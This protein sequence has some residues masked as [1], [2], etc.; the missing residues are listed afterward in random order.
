MR[1]IHIVPSA[2][3]YFDDIRSK[4]FAIVDGLHNLG[5]ETEAFTVQY[6]STGKKLKE[7]VKAA[8]PS[9]HTL[10]ATT[11]AQG[12][13]NS[14][15]DFDVVHVHC[16]FL[17]AAKQI[18]HWKQAFPHKL[19]VVTYY[20]DVPF[21]DGFSWFVKL[22]NAYFLPK[23]F[24]AADVVICS[25]INELAQYRGA[26]YI[27]A[28]QKVMGLDEIILEK[29]WGKFDSRQA[30]AAKVLLVYNSIMQMGDKS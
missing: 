27:P 28:Q 5:I 11:G 13:S 22:Y 1:V 16:P 23:I 6:G 21:S 15:K 24:R 2:F 19:M 20:R 8:S 25:S 3:N 10:A 4:A 12:L 29:K 17:G 7:S 26:K 14:L 18:L 30:V 9:V